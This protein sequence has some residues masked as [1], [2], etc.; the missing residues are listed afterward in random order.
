MKYKSFVS[1]KIFTLICVLFI[2][3]CAHISR[4]DKVGPGWYLV[5]PTDTLY[6]VAWRY[7]IDYKI[8]AQWNQIKS[9][10]VIHPGQ[11]I[12]LI[13][14]K[15]I[16]TYSANTVKQEPKTSK[17]VKTIKK[18][19]TR[20]LKWSWPTKGKR[21][22][23]FSFNDI[24]KRGIDI[25]SKVRQPIVAVESGK[26]VYS[27]NGL[28][29]Y[30]NLIII[31]HNDTYLSAYAQNKNLLVKEGDFVGKGKKIAD[32]GLSKE[33]GFLLHFQIRKNGKPV[34]PMYFLP[35]K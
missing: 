30:K 12:R 25:A 35:K 27:G 6:S 9:P 19:R 33:H 28:E 17:P 26:V 8:L 31:K 20:S 29:G 24:N 16:S 13:K 18:T 22:N 7:D 11:Y 23:R 34:D 3:S 5:K 15:N 1:L 21:L 2:T 4:P 10:Y 32:M 14:P